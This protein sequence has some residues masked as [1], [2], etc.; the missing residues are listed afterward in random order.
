MSGVNREK[1]SNYLLHV[2]AYSLSIRSQRNLSQEDLEDLT[3]VSVNEIS[4][5]ERELTKPRLD[6]LAALAKGLEADAEAAAGSSLG[7]G[8]CFPFSPPGSDLMEQVR[9]ALTGLPEEEQKYLVRL[10]VSAVQR[11]T[12]TITPKISEYRNDEMVLKKGTAPEGAVP[13][14]Y[15]ICEAGFPDIHQNRSST[16]MPF[17]SAAGK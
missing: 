13:F 10:L 14:T 17:I 12:A 3:G 16:A 8:G 1:E 11:I 7:Y 6:I 2:L 5:I 15:W 9:S 4:K